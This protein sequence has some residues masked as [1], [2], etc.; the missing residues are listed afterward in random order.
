MITRFAAVRNAHAA[1]KAALPDRR[2]AEFRT[3]LMEFPRQVVRYLSR[4]KPIM[5]LLSCSVAKS[6]RRITFIGS[7]IYR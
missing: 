1:I 7:K 3:Q 6:T 2:E 5:I 4:L